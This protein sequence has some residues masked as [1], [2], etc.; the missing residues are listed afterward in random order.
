MQVTETSS[1]GLK[2]ELKVT[3]PQ[4]ELSQRFSTRL[5]EVKDQVQLKG[6]RKGKVPAAH[7]K[8]L[9]GRSLM[10][11]VLQAAVEET[12]RTAIKERNERAAH[13]PNINLTEDKDEIEKVLAGQ[14]DLAFTMSYEALPEI[15][16][17][18]LATLKLERE[19]ADVTPEAVDKAVGDLV[20]RALRYEVEAERTAGDGDRV[21]VDFVG[22]IDGNEFEG[23]KS[24]DAQIVLGQSQFIPGFAEGIAGAKAGEERAVNAKFPDTYPQ[25]TLAGKDAVFTVKVKEVAKP[26]RPA[27][28]DDFAKT[29]GTESLAK[30]K[31]LVAAKIGS[32]YAG[33]ARMKLKQQI[34]DGLDKAH[35]FA[36]PQTLVTNEFDAI[37]K[38]ITQGLEQAG[39]TFADEGK[40]EEEVKAE[41][42]KI[43][44]RRVRLG[45]V[46]GE[47]G[48]KTGVE[49]SQEELRRALIEQARRY[50]GQEKFVYEYYEKNPAALIELRAPIFEEKVIDHILGLAKP[51]DKKVT[52]EELLKPD[53]REDALAH[54]GHDHAHDHDHAHGHDHHHHDHDHGHAPHDHAH[55]HDHAQEKK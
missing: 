12:S 13:Q 3:I 1:D 51:V 32:E 55:T 43:A 7:L 9:Y 47:I 44:E 10:A 54:L 18:D 22:R 36:L 29:L 26:I 50:P 46:I 11:E 4:G 19:V 53:A 20:E 37:W 30:L 5:D 6:F 34:L 40:N 49:V 14:S 31:E 52:A 41:Y 24:E 23:G 38:Q 45:L 35:D 15:K 28:D 39:K 27:I 16:V 17:T 33:I 48:D 42:R 2:R 8:K 21:T 25:K